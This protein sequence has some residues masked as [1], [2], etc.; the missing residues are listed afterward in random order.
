MHVYLYCV[1]ASTVRTSAVSM[2]RSVTDITSQSLTVLGRAPQ[3]PRLFLTTVLSG[4]TMPNWRQ[5]ETQFASF[6]LQQPFFQCCLSWAGLLALHF[7][8]VLQL[9]LHLL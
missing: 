9:R 1:I 7:P 6:P 2:H 8:L 3:I 4:V 5:C